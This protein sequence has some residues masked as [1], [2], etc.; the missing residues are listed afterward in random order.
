MPPARLAGTITF[1]PAAITVHLDR[2]DAPRVTRARAPL[3]DEIN[4][5]PQAMPGD[6]AASPAG[7]PRRSASNF[8][9]STFSGVS[10]K[11]AG[12]R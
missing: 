2:P 5:I 9:R 12:S 6:P 11:R 8:K 10:M 7:P 3:I 1:T 4:A